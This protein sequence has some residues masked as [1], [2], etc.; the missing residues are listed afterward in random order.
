[1]I[2]GLNRV[3]EPGAV[4]ET[5]SEL[6]QGA[7]RNDDKRTTTMMVHANE[8]IDAGKLERARTIIRRLQ[9]ELGGYIAQGSG[10]FLAAVYDEQGTLIAKAANSVVSEKCS[11]NHA[12]MN[13]IRAAQRALGTFDLS[14]YHFSLYSTAE[15]CMMCTGAIMWSGI[16]AVYY[17]VPSQRVEAITGFDEGFKPE[18][19]EEFR[20]RGITVYGNIDVE[21]GE[22][23]LED[24]VRCGHT[25]YRP[26][27]SSPRINTP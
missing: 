1:M 25:V 18:W 20:K 16:R 17:G 27:R 3:C 26:Q 10:P 5:R 6:R 15:P 2:G 4:A 23:A 13:V 22:K 9:G 12:E 21:V 7:Q 24:Y 8:E 14:P 11:N 19:L